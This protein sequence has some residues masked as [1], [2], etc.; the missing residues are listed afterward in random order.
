MRLATSSKDLDIPMMYAILRNTSCCATPSNG[1]GRLPKENDVGL[2]DDI[3]RIRHYQQLLHKGNIL[4]MDTT[5]YNT[6]A[7]DLIWVIVSAI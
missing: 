4:E 2:S 1:W 7:L 3:E 6:Y 5:T